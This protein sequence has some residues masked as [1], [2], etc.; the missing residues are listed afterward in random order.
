MRVRNRLRIGFRRFTAAKPAHIAG[1]LE[2]KGGAKVS[3]QS[4]DKKQEAGTPH[5]QKRHAA[6]AK[7]KTL[8]IKKKSAII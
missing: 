5:P 7:N 6:P 4:T 2:T 8:T 1:S 3:A